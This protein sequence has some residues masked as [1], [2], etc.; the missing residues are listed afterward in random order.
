MLGW[1]D[2]K[3]NKNAHRGEGRVPGVPQTGALLLAP[4]A[5]GG[6]DCPLTA[7][8]HG[9]DLHQEEGG[10]HLQETRTSQEG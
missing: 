5:V 4:P 3:W 9:R 8:S 6:G 10:R 1:T 2:V 7:L